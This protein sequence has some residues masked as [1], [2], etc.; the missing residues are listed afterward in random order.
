MQK[1]TIKLIYIL[2]LTILNLFSENKLSNKLSIDE[3]VKM[4]ENQNPEIQSI[5]NFIDAMGK[6]IL[7]IDM[8]FSPYLSSA[9][10]YTLDKSGS[11]FGSPVQADQLNI[12]SLNLSVNKKFDFGGFVSFGYGDTS[13]K[14]KL[15]KAIDIEDEKM[16]KFKVYNLKPFVKIEQ[17]LL[18]DFNS[19]LTKS[20]INKSKFL[21]KAG[22]YSSLF[23]KQQIIFKAKMIY[24]TLS[25]AR[26]VVEF[27]EASLIRTKKLLKWTE[28]R[29]SVDLAD[30]S[31]LYQIKAAYK[32]RE[33]NLKLAHEDELRAMRDFNGLIGKTSNLVTYEIEKISE[34]IKPCA[35]QKDLTHSGTRADVLAAKAQYESSVYADKETKYRSMP[36]ISLVG[37]YST[38]GQDLDYSDSWNQIINAD[39]PAY[40]VGVQCIVPLDY[41]TL[42]KV[43]EGYK[44]DFIA[45]KDRLTSTEI[46]AGNDWEQLQENWKNVKTRLALACEIKT[47]QYDRLEH[48]QDLLEKGRSTMFQMINS[49][50]DLDDSTLNVY[51]IVFEELIL[52]SEAVLFDTQGFDQ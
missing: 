27:R 9:Y 26:E 33:L 4:V 25:L 14:A 20:G 28:K 50:N 30:K 45:A 22:Q 1:N 19:N 15:S 16:S 29:V 7:E 2:T 21:V 6:K 38:K 49:E 3:Y 18:R 48:E 10:N 36:E 46:N 41:K 13:T 44:L 43:R 40:M 34:N 12:G 47:I 17:S 35:K 11:D 51:K 24:W 8:V 52:M 5:N 23:N 31:D 37:Q 39:K 42:L 32:L